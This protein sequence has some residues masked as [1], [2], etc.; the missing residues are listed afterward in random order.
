MEILTTWVICKSLQNYERN[1]KHKYD[2]LKRVPASYIYWLKQTGGNQDLNL[3]YNYHLL[4]QPMP[5]R[6]QGQM[7]D[8]YC[9][10]RI[11][12]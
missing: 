1:T 2:K 5:A 7:I 4:Q 10:E 9:E 3:L 8:T 11:E 12:K 6:E